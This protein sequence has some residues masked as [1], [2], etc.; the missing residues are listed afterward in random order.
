MLDV[1]VLQS[2][3][4]G[5]RSMNRWIVGLLVGLGVAAGGTVLL[6]RGEKPRRFLRERFQQ[7]QDALPEPEDVQKYT[8]QVTERVSQAAGS[9]KD[10]TQQA[11]KKVKTVGSDLGEKA[12]KLT[13]VGS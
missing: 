7:V 4:K 8:R 9:V 13:P 6:L 11:V 3:Q 1:L 12:K 10:T 2:G 5:D